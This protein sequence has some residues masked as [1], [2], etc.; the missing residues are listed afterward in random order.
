[1]KVKIFTFYDPPDRH[2]DFTI[3][4]EINAFLARKKL[5]LALQSVGGQRSPNYDH[6]LLRVDP[7]GTAALFL[8]RT[9]LGKRLEHKAL[10]H[11]R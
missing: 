7:R 2:E 8:I 5:I 6:H 9:N 1:M 10:P 11:T 4:R 3:E